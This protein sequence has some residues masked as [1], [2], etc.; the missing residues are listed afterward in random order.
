MLLFC[1]ATT[2]ELQISENKMLRTEFGPQKEDAKPFMKH[3]KSLEHH[4]V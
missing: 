2:D 3:P 4:D 1:Y